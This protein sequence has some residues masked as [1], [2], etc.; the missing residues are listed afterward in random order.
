MGTDLLSIGKSAVAAQQLL[1]RTTSNNIANVATDN[2]VRQRSV[3][4]DSDVCLG[5]GAVIT[6]RLNDVYKQQE[7]WRDTAGAAYHEAVYQ[8]IHTVD[9]YLSDSSIGLSESMTQ[10]FTSLESAI[11]NP[12]SESERAE[13]MSDLQAFTDRF[14]TL[15]DDIENVVKDNEMKIDEA[16]TQ[17]NDLIKSI[18]QFNNSIATAGKARDSFYYNLV[19]QRD[20]AV[21]QLAELLDIRTVP[22]K[23]NADVI[24]I[25]LASGQTLVMVDS[26]LNKSVWGHLEAV[27]G[28]NDTSA[29]ELAVRFEGS[30]YLT[31]LGADFENV[32]GRVGGLLSCRRE[33]NSSLAGIS[34]LAVS[35]A[36][37]FNLQNSAG[38]DLIGNAG[39]DLFTLPNSAPVVNDDEWCETCYGSGHI[40]YVVD[41][42]AIEKF[43]DCSLCFKADNTGAITACYQIMDD[44]SLSE[45]PVNPADYGII[46]DTRAAWY[47]A[48]PNA[49]VTIKPAADVARKLTLRTTDPRDLALSGSG[50]GP[51]DNSNGILM[52]RLQNTP[53]VANGRAYTGSGDLVSFTERYA[54]ITSSLG[55]VASS[56]NIAYMAADAKL[57]QSRASYD[58]ASGV[59]L[60]EEAAH[61]VQYQ[62]YY[63]AAAKIISAAQNTFQSLINVV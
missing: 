8:Q 16:V 53:A 54:T 62:Q 57:E 37:N 43:S 41:P 1:L 48:E 19:D 10:M 7:V 18:A 4:T 15:Y 3:T 27:P 14:H 13:F 50:M 17:A 49:T 2:Y 12:I 51:S 36:V 26:D 56:E 34:Q 39:Q 24:G 11:N 44:G 33:I 20:A 5:V 45:N 47:Y 23:D 31:K 60:D 55:S 30:T 29:R 38:T 61:L 32:G 63:S 21:A 28:Y 6:Q 35:L 25:N 9:Q 58:S 42:S 22:N 52:S 59:S 40:R 46:V